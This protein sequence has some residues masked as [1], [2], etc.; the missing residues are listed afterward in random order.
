MH[1]LKELTQEKHT[2]DAYPFVLYEKNSDCPSN[3]KFTYQNPDVKSNKF[4][5]PNSVFY[6]T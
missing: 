5:T 3:N 4:L 6:T 2:K 1:I